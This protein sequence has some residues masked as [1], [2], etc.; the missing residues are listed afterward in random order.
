MDKILAGLIT[1]FFCWTVLP[2]LGIVLVDSIVP[3][4]GPYT[5]TLIDWMVFVAISWVIVLCIIRE[6][7]YQTPFN[8]WMILFFVCA[9]F[10]I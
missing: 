7:E 3:I 4:S 9:S 1:T 5:L 8:V 6:Q 10:S 2:F